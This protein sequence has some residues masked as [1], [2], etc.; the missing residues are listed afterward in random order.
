[1]QNLPKN[2]IYILSL[3][4]ILSPG[5]GQAR[6]GRING[7]LR[8]GETGEPL[9]HANVSLKNTGIGAASNNS[10][11]F[12][13]TN[14]PPGQ[15]TLQIM[16]MGYVR[17]E[18]EIS[19]VAGLE[20]RH[21][22]DIDPTFIEGEEVIVTGDRQRFEKQIEISSVSLSMRDVKTMPAFVEA[23]I[24]R[25]LQ[26]LPG[27]QS[28]SDFSSALVVRGGS[29]DE[30]LIML[31]GIEIYNPF[32]LGGVFSTFN[33]DAIADAEFLA[34]GYPAYYGNRISSVLS[35]TGREGNSKHN[36][37]FGS[38]KLGE[39]FDI[40]QAQGEVNL[41]SSKL[42][43]E[44]PLYK[45]SWMLSGRRTYFDQVARL[46]YW[47]KDDPMEWKYYFYDVQGKIIQNINQTNRI[48]FSHYA[49]KDRIFFEI[50]RSD[51]EINFNWDWGNT[52][53]SAKWRW[54]PNS[55]FVSALS[56]ANTVYEFDVDME[57]IA[58]DSAGQSSSTSFVV[59][60]KIDDWTIKE[61]LDWFISSEHTLTTGIE[62]KD[63][64]IDFELSQGDQKILDEHESNM[65][66][67]G[68]VQER[69]QPNPVIMLQAGM[70][71]S[72]YSA[73]ENVYYEPRLGFKYLLSTDLALKGAWGIYN[74][75]LFTAQDEDAILSIVDFWNAIPENYKAK[76]VQHYILG[77]EQWLG[78][79]WFASLEGYYK[80]YSNTLVINP[81]QNFIDRDDDYTEGTAEIYGAEVLLKRNSGK[82]TGWLGYSYMK[83]SQEFDFNGDGHILESDGEVYSSK[84]DQPHSLNLVL[85]YTM[86]KKNSFGL[87]MT[88]SSSNLYTPTVGY[89]YSQNGSYYD[90]ANPYR[91][92]DE[93]KGFRNSARYPN[94]FR[95]DVS[96]S[97]K[98]NPFG[99]D[100]LFK[101]QVINATNHFNTFI[102]NWDLSAGTVEGIG[103]FPFFP[104][105]GL[106][107]KL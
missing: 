9:L 61:N 75:F 59:F 15:Y 29:P 53:N 81:N 26:L 82:L 6:D 14:I 80:P 69:W 91:N 56:F 5:F 67:S 24:F 43:A 11:Y 4:L 60:N 95:V 44:G 99:I 73:H 32:H 30:N 76:S 96:Y 85:N 13:I 104:T 19:V 66:Y 65:I 101:I 7:F 28:S 3:L 100:G 25:T 102:Y 45:G 63:L 94:Y 92:L 41:L 16:M 37:L 40:S 78:E 27:V 79:G 50:G 71:A 18:K 106:E 38:K 98:I 89:I 22:F 86:N 55:S 97:R 68:I 72:K 64:G 49:G 12:I 70:R 74:Q 35:I 84:Y 90:L 62:I 8:D 17:T 42:L 1:M 87:T 103:M 88:S 77:I 57:L 107:F 47:Y 21:D 83:S 39:F 2:I 31:D 105:F 34:G 36:I 51:N 20:E 46:Y 54:I 58:T 48:T 33:A 93:I 10:G 23:D 52:T